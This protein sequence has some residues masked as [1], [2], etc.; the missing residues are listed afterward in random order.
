MICESGIWVGPEDSLSCETSLM[1]GRRGGV[2]G[3]ACA[4]RG[5]G[6]LAGGVGGSKEA[7]RFTGGE[8]VAAIADGAAFT[9]CLLYTSPSPR[10]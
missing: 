4:N 10:D 2:I 7:N 3:A 8:S 5:L 9:R 1:E 6:S